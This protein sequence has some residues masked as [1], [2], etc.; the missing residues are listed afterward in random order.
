[1]L[2]NVE[3]Y[4][5]VFVVRFCNVSCMLASELMS[6]MDHTTRLRMIDDDLTAREFFVVCWS[7]GSPS[8]TQKKTKL[9]SGTPESLEQKYQP[10]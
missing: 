2:E 10:Q 6:T 1:M 8:T 4:L 9:Q 5:H 7:P 3:I